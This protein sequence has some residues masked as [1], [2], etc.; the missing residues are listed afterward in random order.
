[1]RQNIK[2]KILFLRSKNS[3]L[4]LN[5]NIPPISNQ[6]HINEVLAFCCYDAK[7]LISKCDS[8]LGERWRFKP[9]VCGHL[10]K[11]FNSFDFTQKLNFDRSNEMKKDTSISQ[12]QLLTREKGKDE[13][14]LDDDGLLRLSI[15]FE[16][17]YICVGLGTNDILFIPRLHIRCMQV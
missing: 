1:L 15:H 6:H 13:N 8:L 4:N 5:P 11:K 2:L 10:L 17:I 14:C 12:V 16:H 7:E 3:S 9:K